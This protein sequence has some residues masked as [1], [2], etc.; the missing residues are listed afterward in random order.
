MPHKPISEQGVV[1]SPYDSA[2]FQ[3][4]RSR[5]GKLSDRQRFWYWPVVMTS[6]RCLLP[7]TVFLGH[8]PGLK[9]S[10]RRMFRCGFSCDTPA[11]WNLLPIELCYEAGKAL[12]LAFGHFPNVSDVVHCHPDGLRQMQHGHPSLDLVRIRSCIRTRSIVGLLVNAFLS[13]VQSEFL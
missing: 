5:S 12:C 8:T 11:H 6:V 9:L 2:F 1:S 3:Y 10:Y 7:R 13:V 4:I